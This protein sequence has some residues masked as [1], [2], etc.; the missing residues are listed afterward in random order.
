VVQPFA[1]EFEPDRSDQAIPNTTIDLIE[2][3]PEFKPM[4]E[5][6]KDLPSGA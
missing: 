6:G 1:S 4:A 3:E 5:S 2:S